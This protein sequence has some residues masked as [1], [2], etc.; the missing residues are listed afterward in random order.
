MAVTALQRLIAALSKLPGIGQRS[1]E[2]MAMHLV[3]RR[4]ELLGELAAAL[5]E[6]REQVTA[7]GRCGA[8]TSTDADPCRLCT[9]AG[10]DDTL[11]CVVED[12]A[13]IITIE[14][15]GGYQGRYHALMGTLSPARRRGPDDLRIR[16]LIERVRSEGIREVIL[17]LNTDVEGDATAAF[18]GEALRDEPVAIT[19]LAF[20]LPAGSGI[21]YADPV[22]IDRAMK[23]RREY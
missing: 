8:P 18:L 19:R 4:R 23:G 16:A 7:C 14:R 17:A 10:R 13:D 15:A 21:R 3:V 2:R 9:R 11:L 5:S 1:A 12:P 6:A 20:G 22:T